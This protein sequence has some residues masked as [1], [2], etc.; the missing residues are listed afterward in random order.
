MIE[1]FPSPAD[2]YRPAVGTDHCKRW[3]VSLV[4]KNGNAALKSGVSLRGEMGMGG[5]VSPD[6]YRF[7][8]LYFSGLR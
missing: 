7:G 6:S 3:S 2:S 4:P 8:T 5:K 1:D